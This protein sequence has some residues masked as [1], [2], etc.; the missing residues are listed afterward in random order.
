M[1]L[2]QS[3]WLWCQCHIRQL[4]ISKWA[5]KYFLKNLSSTLTPSRS[6]MSMSASKVRLNSVHNEYMLHP[7]SQ[8][9]WEGLCREGD[10]FIFFSRGPRTAS[11]TRGSNV[12]LT[13]KGKTPPS[14]FWG[15][16]Q[17][18]K[19]LHAR[20]VRGRKHAHK[21]ARTPQPPL[22]GQEKALGAPGIPWP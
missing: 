22:D 8:D 2:A 3:V 9:S 16:L 11:G 13:I 18:Y 14:S 19:T 7:G 6:G 21:T 4:I 5:C 10:I 12:C 17:P 20:Q 15:C 1:W